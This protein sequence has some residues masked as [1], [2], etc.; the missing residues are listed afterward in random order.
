MDRRQ[1]LHSGAGVAAGLLLLK[2][3]T[4]F[5]YE[6]NSGVRL[7][8]L[9]CGGR[10]TGVAT[11]F[12]KNTSAQVVALADLLP[13]QLAAGREHFNQVNAGLGHEPISEKLLF[14]GPEAYKKIASSP[15]VDLIQI[16]TPPFFHVEHL[17]EAV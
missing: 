2:S 16:S 13:D 9:G 15:D 12:A 1:F 7:G 10:G 4:A 5:G 11:S 6:A 17:G 8:L 3:R 14:L